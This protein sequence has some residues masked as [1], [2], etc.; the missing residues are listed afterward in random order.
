MYCMIFQFAIPLTCFLQLKLIVEILLQTQRFTILLLV[1]NIFG[2]VALFI[3]ILCGP[4][5]LVTQS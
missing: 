3:Y 5:K 2:D 4:Y 1:I